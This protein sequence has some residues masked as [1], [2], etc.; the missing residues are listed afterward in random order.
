MEVRNS[1]MNGGKGLFATKKYSKD[2][3]VYV[4]SGDIYDKPTRETIHIGNNKHIYDN[5]GIYINHSFNPNIYVNGYN[6]VAL[7][8]INIDDE[9][10]FNYNKTEALMANPFYYNGI[11]VYGNPNSIVI[12]STYEFGPESVIDKYCLLINI[13]FIMFGL[14]LFYFY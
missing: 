11:L 14:F 6:L 8:N 2:D 4:L 1:I 3:I 7:C 9:I 5:Y 10:T 13:T 12:G